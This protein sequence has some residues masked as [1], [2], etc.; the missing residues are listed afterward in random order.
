MIK[1]GNNILTEHKKH[2]LEFRADLKQINFLDQRFYKTKEGEYYPSV[3]TILNYMP[4]S[5]FFETWLKDVGHNA[6]LIVNRAAR[7]GAQVHEAAE[8]L[9]KGETVEWL[10]D[11]GNAKYSQIVWEMILKFIEFWRSFKGELVIAEQFLYSKEY[12]YAG[13]CD[14]VVRKDDKL[15]L[16]DIKTSNSI[17]KSYHLQL[18]AY[19]HAWEELTGDKI[20][21]TGIIWLKSAKRGESKKVDIYQGKGWELIQ[22]DNIEENF[23]LFNTVYSLYKLENPEIEPT[24]E[25]LPISV[26]L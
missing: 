16:L 24:F 5:K 18:A 10:D 17:H 7:E 22:V 9:L 20:D 4:K 25:T 6:D 26:K 3:T 15:W 2:N 12:K 23:N 1:E 19:A 21:H 8:L 14:I 11:Y 13:T